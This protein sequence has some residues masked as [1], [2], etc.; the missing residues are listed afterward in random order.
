[1]GT[2]F[3]PSLRLQVQ[4]TFCAVRLILDFPFYAVVKPVKDRGT[5][6][7]RTQVTILLLTRHR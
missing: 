7:T 1:M 3:F 4:A 6:N 5:K 2:A